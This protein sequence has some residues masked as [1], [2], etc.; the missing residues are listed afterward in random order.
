MQLRL[1]K[2][3]YYIQNSKMPDVAHVTTTEQ[4]FHYPTQCRY[5]GTKVQNPRR[6]IHVHTYNVVYLY[7]AH[8]LYMAGAYAPVLCTR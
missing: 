7:V 6:Y 1:L 2:L 3:T 8:A 4:N 5:E